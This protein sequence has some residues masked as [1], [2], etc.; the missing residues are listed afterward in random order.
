MNRANA[1]VYDPSNGTVTIPV[2]VM[3]QTLS[4]VT[5]AKP[6]TKNVP[7]ITRERDGDKVVWARQALKMKPQATVAEVAA[8]AHEAHPDVSIPNFRYL[9]NKLRK[10][11]AVRGRKSK[12]N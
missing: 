5:E 1:A 3:R 11:P 6:M 8:T 7:G 2:R 12:A 10:Q 9:V 4:I